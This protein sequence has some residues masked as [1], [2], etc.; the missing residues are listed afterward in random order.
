MVAGEDGSVLR[1]SPLDI[2]RV[3]EVEGDRVR[4]YTTGFEGHARLSDVVAVEQADRYFSDQI[5]ANPSLAFAYL[6]RCNVRF[7]K[8]DLNRASVDCEEA[9]RLEP[10]NP[11]VHLMRAMI[12][13]GRGESK[14]SLRANMTKQFV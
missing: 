13:D 14:S 12:F 3:L 10:K 4:L 5:R 7:R 1:V 9:L 8:H 2:Y 11:S 6:A